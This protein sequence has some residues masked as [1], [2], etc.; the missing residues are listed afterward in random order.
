MPRAESL[1]VYEEVMES[2]PEDDNSNERKGRDVLTPPRK[3]E[4]EEQKNE[5]GARST[6]SAEPSVADERVP[7]GQEYDEADELDNNHLDVY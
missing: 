2:V 5:T 3:N 7:V 6:S 1:I 4:Q